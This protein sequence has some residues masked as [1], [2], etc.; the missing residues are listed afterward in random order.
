MRQVIA[1]LVGAASWSGT[2][3]VLHRFLMHEMRGRGLASREHLLHHA[4]V[5]YF[6]PAS[7]KALSAAGTAA[8]AWPLAS[9]LTDRRTATSYTAGLLSMYFTYEVIH[10]RAHT[11]PPR[12]RYGRWVRRNHLHHHFGAPMRNIGVT[13]PVWDRVFGTYD[14]PGRVV[15]PRRMAPT[16]L[17]DEH[18]DVRPEHAADYEARGRVRTTDDQ[19]GRDRDDAFSNTAPTAAVLDV[20][21]DGAVTARQAQPA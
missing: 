14:D 4:D 16:W 7:K 13:S 9:A 15:V 19:R 18:G 21:A 10:R 12:G 20:G 2:E 5:T 6:A 1:G 8:V 11:H 3:Y 17:L